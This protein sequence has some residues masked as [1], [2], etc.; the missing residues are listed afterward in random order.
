M[1]GKTILVVED[2]SIQREVLLAL[3][4]KQ[5][6]A[7]R[8]AADGKTG[9]DLLRSGLV[10]D[11]ILLDMMIPPP[12]CDGWRFLEKQRKM[13]ALASI[14]V[15]I[16]TSLSVASEEWAASLGACC[17]IRKPIDVEPVLASVQACLD[18]PR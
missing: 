18:R 6:Y 5:G 16:M 9:L 7:V 1:A 2:D 12:D 3:L 10:P 15:V 8:A 11:L 13:P 14:P 4:E 17:L